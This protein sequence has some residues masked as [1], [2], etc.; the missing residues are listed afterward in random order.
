MTGGEYSREG[1][2]DG[3]TLVDGA[4]NASVGDGLWR[5]VAVAGNEYR[6]AIRNRW[7][8]ALTALFGVFALALVTFSGSSVSPEGFDRVVA[9]LAVL[10]VYLVP[11]AALAFGYDTVV[12][13]NESG[14][15]D[16]LFALPVARAHVVI[17]KFL[18]RSLI[19]AAATLV[20]FGVAGGFLLLEHGFGGSRT[21]LGFALA[22]VG[23]GLSFLAM[24]TL[25]S[26][27]AREKTHSLGVSLLAWA[28]FILVHDVLSLGVIAAFPLSDRAVSALLLANPSGTYRALVLGALG[29]GGDAGFAAVLTAAGLSPPVLVTALVVWIV[30]PIA[31]AAVL[32]RRRRL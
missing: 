6:I 32:V 7:A 27:V 23:L 10:A 8:L 24:S 17:G 20:G 25:I 4:Q 16:V 14:W 11:L 18:G 13:S 19:L 15:L 29:A 3:V 1:E 26:T 21:Y 2:Y 31:L 5:I 12:G 28:W 9:S 22:T 30:V